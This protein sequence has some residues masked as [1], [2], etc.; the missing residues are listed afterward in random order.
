MPLPKQSRESRSD[1]SDIKRD[2]DRQQKE[3]ERW[4]R[5]YQEVVDASESRENTLK[6][7]VRELL[8]EQQKLTAELRN[9]HSTVARLKKNIE[10]IEQSL[11]NNGEDA[12]RKKHIALLN[13]Y[14][15]LSA[16]FE[17]LSE[18]VSALS[19]QLDKTRT[20]EEESRKRCEESIMLIK[21]DMEREREKADDATKNLVSLER[22]YSELLRN[23]RE[24]NNRLIGIKGAV[25]L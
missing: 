11:A 8:M 20:A 14:S 23:Y 21:A 3:A 13:S 4:K 17:D 19:E 24:L 9:E 1:W 22:S 5:L 16:Q 6:Q 15:D 18:Q 7:Q 2:A 25:K 10:T 12:L